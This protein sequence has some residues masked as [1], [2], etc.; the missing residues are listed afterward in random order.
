M[1]SAVTQATPQMAV[2]INPNPPAIGEMVDV[3]ILLSN[4]DN[5]V[6]GNL[7]VELVWPQYL[8]GNIRGQI[9]GGACYG[10]CS[11]GEVF[12]WDTSDLGS[13]ASGQSKLIAV[14][15]AISNNTPD[16]SNLDFIIRLYENGYLRQTINKTITTST[17]GELD[18]TIQSRSNFVQAGGQVIYDVVYGNHSATPAQNTLL[19]VPV[20]PGTTYASAT[21]NGVL[22]NGVVEWNL[23][24]LPDYSHGRQ[25]VTFDVN[26]GLNEGDFINI[27]SA[28]ISADYNFVNQSAFADAIGVIKAHETLKFSV[29]VNPNPIESGET[30][31][32]QL[33]ISNTGSVNED[34]SGLT[35][36]CVDYVRE[37]Y[38]TTGG[39]TN[40][41]GCYGGE[42]ITWSD[43]ALGVLPPGETVVVSV[44]S[45]VNQGTNSGQVIPFEALVFVDGYWRGRV[46]H[47]IAVDNDSGLDLT[48]SPQN[49]PVA[50]NNQLIYNLSYGN[51]STAQAT[52]AVLS[53]PLPE[54]A[55]FVSASGNGSLN[56]DVVEWTIGT[57]AAN[58][59]GFHQLTLLVDG[60][61]TDGTPLLVE[62]AV[63]QATIN[64][65]PQEAQATAVT[66]VKTNEPLRFEMEVNPNPVEPTETFDI[67]LKITNTGVVNE[68]LSGLKFQCVDYVRIYYKATGGATNY[69]G[70]DAGEF[71]DWSDAVLGILPPG[72]SHVI[73][74]NSYVNQGVASG[75]VIPFEVMMYAGGLW[76]GSVYDNVVVDADSGLDLAVYPQSDPVAQGAQLLYKLNYGNHSNLQ[77]NN[78]HLTFPI[79]ED[80]TFVSAS[81]NGVFNNGVVFWNL[82]ELATGQFGQEQVIVAVDN[83]LA[84][85]ET[86]VVNAAALKASINYLTE[87]V[88]ATAVSQVKMNEPLQFEM[89]V[90]PNPVEPSET[91]DIQLKITN[92]G[93][94]NEDLSDLLFQCVDYVRMYYKTT[95]GATNYSGCS[96]GEFIAWSDA[97][98]GLLPPG[99]SMVLSVNSYA[100]QGVASGRVIPFEAMVYVD[101]LWR[102][103]VYSN[104]TVDADSGLDLAIDPQMDPVMPGAQLTYHLTYG[105]HSGFQAI[106]ASLVFSVPQGTSFVSASGG[107]IENNGTVTWQLSQINSGQGG[108]EQVVVEVD[109]ALPQ[110]ALLTVENG[111]I[112]A[113]IDGLSQSSHAMS[114]SEV[115]LPVD[116]ALDIMAWPVP[117]DT[118]DQ[119]NML[120]DIKNL[121]TVNSDNLSLRLMWPD[122]MDQYP[123]ATNGGSCSD[124]GIGG[125]LSWDENDLSLLPPQGILNISVVEDVDYYTQRGRVIPFEIE[126][127]E[128]GIYRRSISDS[129]L[130][131][132][133]TDFDN[134]GIADPFDEDDDDDGMPDWWENYYGLNPYNPADAHQ[135]PDNDNFTN[136]QEYLNGT[137]PFISDIPDL[138]FED[139]F[140]S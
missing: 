82:A 30:F 73:S 120:I 83:G 14:N 135:D 28:E 136:L 94:V 107:G 80:T 38:K 109:S 93:M 7:S 65:L 102:G 116:F 100:G 98:L 104:T 10:S 11:T 92:T 61:L 16:G 75:R 20:P 128:G 34:L 137:H 121:Q 5:T 118:N 132:D 113:D 111:F 122:Y 44:N 23:N 86:L 35:F 3:Q 110:G 89:E 54:G 2:E 63:L 57:I 96:G 48:V 77:A 123:V 130:V 22:N 119:L 68:D 99:E 139:G 15:S 13:L 97:N 131:G 126:L 112:Q 46:S 17:T 39:A 103:G 114:S 40:Y 64:Y 85:G 49:N 27:E 140:E 18:L 74:V 79:P 70:C 51:H 81:G 43:T 108:R 45:Y 101:G 29:E 24:T 134:D 32:I 95:G 69:S 106:N 26:A 52:N 9:G 117:V 33:K 56:G 6:T 8:H 76:R 124:C 138:I 36:Q 91:F 105:N 72:E 59:H 71:I 50:Q 66:H 41:N 1:V 67:Q 60:G 19:S 78:T 42:F 87:T 21:G 115:N 12:L 47:S 62:S 127:F 53:F 4:S 125:Y 84:D 58:S 129:V 88:Q 37:Y 90:N 31:D 133:F 25:Q 55:I